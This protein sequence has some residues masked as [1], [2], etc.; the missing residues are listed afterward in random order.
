MNESRFSSR[1]LNIQSSDEIWSSKDQRERERL[2]SV[3][4]NEWHELGSLQVKI[5]AKSFHWSGL[6]GGCFCLGAY[7][8]L[9]VGVVNLPETIR[10]DK[11]QLGALVIECLENFHSQV[12]VEIKDAFLAV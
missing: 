8:C 1:C 9:L 7:G 2:Q 4:K 12:D 5:K 10:F 11:A 3:L 6:I